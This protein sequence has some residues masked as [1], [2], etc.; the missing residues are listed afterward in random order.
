M[1]KLKKAFAWLFGNFSNSIVF[2][3]LPAIIV[4]HFLISDKTDIW[5]LA[6]VILVCSTYTVILVGD[7]VGY[8]KKMRKLDE[9]L[10]KE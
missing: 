3:W 10:G 9:D 5:D 4:N 2:C 8:R 1:V 6:L 7:I